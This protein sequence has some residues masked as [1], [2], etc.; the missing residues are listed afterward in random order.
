MNGQPERVIRKA[1]L[2]WINSYPEYGWAWIH[3]SA[4]SKRG[5]TYFTRG[6]YDLDYVSDIEGIWMARPLYIE[7]K[8]PGAS[9][10][11]ARAAGQKEFL[12]KVAARGGIGIYAYSLDQVKQVLGDFK[13]LDFG[14]VVIWTDPSQ[15]PA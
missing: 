14:K 6:K 8:A 4:A 13:P 3:K 9:P 15:S 7:T 2:D 1:I 5:G 12:S 10:K 11:K